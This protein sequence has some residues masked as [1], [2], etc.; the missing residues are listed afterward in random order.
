MTT[1]NSP[2]DICFVF[3]HGTKCAN[4]T[5]YGSIGGLWSANGENIYYNS[6][7]VSIGDDLDV[8]NNLNVSQNATVNGYMFVNDSLVIGTKIPSE[9]AGLT[10]K[11]TIG[12]GIITIDSTSSF[13]MIKFLRGG[14]EMWA[15]FNGAS[16]DY[17]IRE[18]GV[19]NRFQIVEGGEV[20]ILNFLNV[21]NDAWV[22][23]N[24]Y[25]GGNFTGN[26]IYGG[27]WYHNDSGEELT[28]ANSY[29]NYTLFMTD[30]ENRNGFGVEGLGVGESSNLT[31]QVSGLY[32]ATYMA[33]GDG[34]NNHEYVTSIYVNEVN[35]IECKNHHKMSAGGD[36]ITQSGTCFITIMAGDKVSLRIR[37]EDGAGE[38]GNY[39]GANLNLVR[40]GD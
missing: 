5:T 18:D 10:V 16:D 27:M 32:S 23:K 6:G 15:T 7:N 35:K 25:A 38:T 4:F 39:Y 34:Q 14:A 2:S 40:I 26:Q 11:N 31:A 28:F 1:N 36:I 21:S 24:L 3:E 13:S 20:K 12:A 22:G 33:I 30:A 17:Y 19:S 9:G 8:G 29:T 37:D